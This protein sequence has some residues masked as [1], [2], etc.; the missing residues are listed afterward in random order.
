MGIK[1]YILIGASI[2]L[3]I[4]VI[5]LISILKKKPKL[6]KIIDDKTDLGELIEITYSNSGD[7]NGNTDFVSL[8]IKK[9]TMTTEYRT[10]HSEPLKVKVYKVDNIDK[11][12]EYIN[13]YNIPGW[14]K[15]PIDPDIIVLDAPIK[16]IIFS[17]QKDGKINYYNIDFNMMIEPFGR[18]ILNEFVKEFLLLKKKDNLIKEYT[19]KE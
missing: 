11:I 8:D 6:K 18:D 15:L 5:A 2:L 10:M 7:S 1:E 13:K 12:I 4:I 3:V 16:S 19:K 17:Y 9:K 14:N